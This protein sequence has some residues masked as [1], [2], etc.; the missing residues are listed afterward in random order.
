MNF[1]EKEDKCWVEP[2][3]VL[4]KLEDP[5]IKT[6]GSGTRLRCRF[7]FQNVLKAE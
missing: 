3:Q 6:D 5:E 7:K 1:P 2:E 4:R